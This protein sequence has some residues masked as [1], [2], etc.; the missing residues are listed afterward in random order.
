MFEKTNLADICEIQQS[1]GYTMKLIHASQGSVA[2]RY[3]DVDNGG[4]PEVISL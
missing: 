2:G 3:I 4:H 1:V